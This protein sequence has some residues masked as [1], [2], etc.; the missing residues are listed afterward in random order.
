MNNCTA[1]EAQFVDDNVP[2]YLVLSKDETPGDSMPPLGWTLAG[3]DIDK[4]ASPGPRSAL[5]RLGGS[6]MAEP[7]CEMVRNAAFP[8]L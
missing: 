5:V 8:A 2:Q 4:S 6:D 1:D 3:R 7:S